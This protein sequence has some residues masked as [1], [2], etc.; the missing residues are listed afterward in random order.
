MNEYN[1]QGRGE[2][3]SFKTKSEDENFKIATYYLR[4]K[5]KEI[6]FKVK[7]FFEFMYLNINDCRDYVKRKF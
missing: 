2:E 6:N 4:L 5:Q 1:T 7:V 3:I